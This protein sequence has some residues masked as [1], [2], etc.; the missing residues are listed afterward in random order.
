MPNRIKLLIY[1]VILKNCRFCGFTSSFFL[2]V[3]HHLETQHLTATCCLFFFFFFSFFLVWIVGRFIKWRGKFL[4][5][6]THPDLISMRFPVIPSTFL[7]HWRG[8]MEATQLLQVLTAAPMIS[9]GLLPRMSQGTY[10]VYWHLVQ[11]TWLFIPLIHVAYMDWADVWQPLRVIGEGKQDNSP[12]NF[13]QALLPFHGPTNS[14]SLLDSLLIQKMSC[15]LSPCAA[16]SCCHY[17]SHPFR[18]LL[19]HVF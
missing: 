5:T 13:P 3:I 8:I 9:R 7:S 15:S 6:A 2:V 11:P 17:Y 19:N 4:C 10:L 12:S 18:I 1:L 16:T 14:W